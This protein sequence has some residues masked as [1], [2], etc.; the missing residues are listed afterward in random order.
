MS[1]ELLKS[2]ISRLYSILGSQ[3]RMLAALVKKE[4]EYVEFVEQVASAVR[5][6]RHALLVQNRLSLRR[7]LS[8]ERDAEHSTG[9]RVERSTLRSSAGFGLQARLSQGQTGRPEDQAHDDDDYPIRIEFNQKTFNPSYLLATAAAE[10]PQPK[11]RAA[12]PKEKKLS[13]DTF[14]LAQMAR[15]KPRQSILD[16]IQER[17]SLRKSVCKESV[18]ATWDAS[19]QSERTG[20]LYDKKKSILNASTTRERIS[21]FSPGSS[22]RDPINKTALEDRSERTGSVENSKHLLPLARTR[23]P[24]FL[25]I[26]SLLQG[27]L[28]AGQ[29]DSRQLHFSKERPSLN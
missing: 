6:L 20:T 17:V 13:L 16:P 12:R 1:V 18:L 3:H 14:S 4:E 28:K 10:L 24:N 27:R 29:P 11:P 25:K 7:N 26:K 15:P 2:K 8:Q 9:K 21:E 23:P 19:S 22:S 5:N